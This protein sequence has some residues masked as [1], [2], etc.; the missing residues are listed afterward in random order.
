MAESVQTQ[1]HFTIVTLDAQNQ[2]LSSRK[3]LTIAVVG[4]FVMSVLH[5]PVVSRVSIKHVIPKVKQSE[6]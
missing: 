6:V 4:A 2:F 3:A 5:N 1:G